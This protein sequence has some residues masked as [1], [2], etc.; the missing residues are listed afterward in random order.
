L[1]FALPSQDALLPPEELKKRQ[2]LR[3]QHG[4]KL[5]EINQKRLQDKRSQLQQEHDD[6]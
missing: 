1:P 2:D 4:Q 3:I 6:L 5:K